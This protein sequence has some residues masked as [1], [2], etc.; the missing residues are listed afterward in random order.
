MNKKNEILPFESLESLEFLMRKSLCTSFLLTSHSKKRPNNIVFG[1]TF[2]GN[3]LDMVEFGVDSYTPLNPSAEVGFGQRPLLTVCGNEWEL[4]ESLTTAKSILMSCF[5]C[6]ESDAQSLK[7]IRH[8]L[9]FSVA[10]GKVHMESFSLA[11]KK[12]GTKIPKVVLEPTGFT[13]ILTLRR[14][15]AADPDAMVQALKQPRDQNIIRAK[16]V[17]T[18][19]MAN[20]VGRIHMQKQDLSTF[21]TRKGKALK[22]KRT[23]TETDTDPAADSSALEDLDA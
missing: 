21:V 13:A 2:N 5:M 19:K 1:R 22:R 11:L 10:L 23:E 14:H 8:L 20:T 18:D 6:E 16:N 15:Q 12:S 7:G 17:S 3:V 9:S 4:E